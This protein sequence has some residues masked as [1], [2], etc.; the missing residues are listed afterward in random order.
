MTANVEK[1]ADF[2]VMTH[3]SIEAVTPEAGVVRRVGAG[4]ENL[5]LVENQM[6]GGYT[7]A[8]HSHPHDQVVYVVSGYIRVASAGQRFDL[9]DGESFAVRGGIEHQVTA[10]TDSLVLDVFSPCRCDFLQTRT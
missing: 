2:E 3:S 6:A 4:N 5:L 1:F 9:H 8:R 10:V 7:G